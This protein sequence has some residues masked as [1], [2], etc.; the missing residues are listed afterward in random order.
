[1]VSIAS[2]LISH[3]ETMNVSQ[4]N[5]ASYKGQRGIGRGCSTIFMDQMLYFGGARGGDHNTQVCV[6]ASL[7]YFSLYF[8]VSIVENCGINPHPLYPK[9]P[10]EFENGACNSFLFPSPKVLLC[11]SSSGNSHKECHT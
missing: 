8:K 7:V 3:S 10:F 5:P 2:C 1:M 9:L 4:L 6:F 11:F